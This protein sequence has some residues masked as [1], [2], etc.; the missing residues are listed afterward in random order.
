M[1]WWRR[2]AAEDRCDARVARRL[3]E[4]LDAS[5]NRAEALRVAQAHAH[6]LQEEFGTGPDPQ[7]QALTLQ[8]QARPDATEPAEPAGREQDRHDRSANRSTIA[9]LPFANLSRDAEADPFAAGLH[10]DLLTELSR[11][12][13]VTVIARTS[14]LGYRDSRLP[15][16]QIARELGVGTLV[17][18][19]VQSSGGRL[20]V[21]VQLIDARSGGHLW[22]ERYDRVL[23]TDS[24][25]DIQTD[26]VERIA[27]SLRTELATTGPAPIPAGARPT[28]D[29]EAYRLHAQGHQQLVQL[30]DASLRQ[31]LA[32][33]RGAIERDPDY[34][35]AWVGLADAL[36]ALLDYGYDDSTPTMAE[37]EAAVRRALELQPEL[38]EAHAVLG[39]LHGIQRKGPA[40]IRALT[41]AVELMPTYGQA[42]DWLSW[43]WQCLGRNGQALESARRAVELEPLLREAVSNLAATLMTNGEPAQALVESR[44]IREIGPGWTSGAFYEGLVLYRLGRFDE[45]QSVL[46]GLVVEWVG[47]GPRCALALACA[48][49]G[50]AARA[51]RL[52]AELRK[53]GEWFSVGLVH[54]ALG[55]PDAAFDAFEK[56]TDWGA[57]WPTLAVHGYFPDLMDTLDGDARFRGMRANIHRAWGLEPDGS[58]P[59]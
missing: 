38:A 55:E 53:A 20:R 2:R 22:A 59:A 49:S 10:D 34:A 21:N 27:G 47:A 39:K 16:Q 58:I 28:S 43:H 12:H 54:A 52:Q 48:A 7:V 19:A 25:F 30:T 36:T 13:G 37:A 14:V 8:L 29:L 40:A 24:L 1:Q 23:S 32:Y 31:A 3:M 4:A 18:G 51:Q 42:H 50:D 11:V 6:A 26:L 9:V 33:F 56:V 15:V 45:A 35:L 17:E 5:G 46:Q 44:R 57:Y 41:R